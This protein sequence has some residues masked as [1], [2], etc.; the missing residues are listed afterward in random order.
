MTVRL[1]GVLHA[2]K[3][4][5]HPEPW[6][7]RIEAT[8]VQEAITIARWATDHA[9]AAF[10]QIGVDETVEQARLVLRW[11]ERHRRPTFS[12]SEAYQ[13]LRGSFA[14][15]DAMDRP[16][17]VLV[18]HNYVRRCAV[19]PRLRAGRPPTAIYDVN[20]L[21]L[22][23]NPRNTRNSPSEGDEGDFQDSL[24]CSQRQG[25]LSSNDDEADVGGRG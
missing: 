10:G 18:A 25:L 1:A 17:E 4:A 3:Q 21:I 7:F 22:S 24:D 16:L 23:N 2:V 19:T 9:K 13:A 8:T 12:R 20:P 11:I 5:H 14:S 6:R 15:P